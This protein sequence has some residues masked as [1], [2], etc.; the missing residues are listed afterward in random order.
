[1]SKGGAGGGRAGGAF[2]C[3]SVCSIDVEPER[4]RPCPGLEDDD[5]DIVAALVGEAAMMLLLLLA[6][7]IIDCWA[8]CK[9]CDRVWFRGLA[10]NPTLRRYTGAPGLAAA[11]IPFSFAAGSGGAECE[12]PKGGR[13]SA[14]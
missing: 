13:C 7:T 2:A 10:G 5:I 8:C 6:S 11:S 1:M 14:S 4:N 9:V 12:P 3:G